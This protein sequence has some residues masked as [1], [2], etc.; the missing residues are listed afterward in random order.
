MPLT[1]ADLPKI[2]AAAQA[3]LSAVDVAWSV[4]D[5]PN[6]AQRFIAS[7]KWAR[8]PESLDGSKITKKELRIIIR[9]ASALQ[10]AA[11]DSVRNPQTLAVGPACVALVA[12][13]FAALAD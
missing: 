7:V 2:A 1:L 4:S 8:N 5:V 12:V 11:L 9:R 6:C 13:C 10:V 3:V